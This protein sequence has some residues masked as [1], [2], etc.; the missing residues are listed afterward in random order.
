MGFAEL[1]LQFHDIHFSPLAWRGG[2]RHVTTVDVLSWDR[3]RSRVRALERSQDEGE[4]RERR[5][6]R[7]EQGL[8]FGLSAQ[9]S[10]PPHAN[11][12]RSPSLRPSPRNLK[13]QR[14]FII[15]SHLFCHQDS[16][17]GVIRATTLLQPTVDI[18]I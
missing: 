1:R 7:V 15:E 11:E 5:E 10:P 14:S 2:R 6:R 9:R 18:Q 12:P 16:A 4:R 17:R 13:L 8:G 3:A